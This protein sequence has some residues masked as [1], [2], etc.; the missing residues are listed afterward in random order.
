MKR[1]SVLRGKQVIVSRDSTGLS[2]RGFAG[3]PASLHVTVK[4]NTGEEGGLRT[5]TGNTVWKQEA[6]SNRGVKKIK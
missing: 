2:E 4:Q 3:Q 5:D 6:E 1:V